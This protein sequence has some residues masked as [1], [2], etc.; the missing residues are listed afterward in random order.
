MTGGIFGPFVGREAGDQATDTVDPSNDRVNLLG[1]AGLLGRQ[2]GVDVNPLESIF[3]PSADS[4]ALRKRQEAYLAGL[5]AMKLKQREEE[6][7]LDFAMKKQLLEHEFG[8]TSKGAGKTVG[9]SSPNIQRRLE[10]EPNLDG[11]RQ[12]QENFQSP[13][14]PA[15]VLRDLQPFADQLTNPTGLG[16]PPSL[17]DDSNVEFGTFGV[18]PSA[19]MLQMPERQAQAAAVATD[20]AGIEQA[21]READ[22][23]LNPS[24]A[25]RERDIQALERGELD[26]GGLAIDRVPNPLDPEG[27]VPPD[28]RQ[29]MAAEVAGEIAARVEALKDLAKQEP[30]SGVLPGLQAARKFAGLDPVDTSEL[31]PNQ[32]LSK[33]D[34]ESLHAFNN[35]ELEGAAVKGRDDRLAASKQARLVKTI[36]GRREAQRALGQ[37]KG[38]FMLAAIGLKEQLAGSREAANIAARGLETMK[39]IAAR[40]KAS[41]TSDFYKRAAEGLD[42]AAKGEQI[43][44]KI[45]AAEINNMARISGQNIRTLFTA[46]VKSGAVDLVKLTEALSKG[47]GGASSKGLLDALRGSL[48]DVYDDPA[49]DTLQTEINNVL[50]NK[51]SEQTKATQLRPLMLGAM[52]KEDKRRVQQEIDRLDKNARTRRKDEMTANI[53][54]SLDPAATPNEIAQAIK[55]HDAGSLVTVGD[56]KSALGQGRAIDLMVG[57][58][59]E[60]STRADLQK[61]RFHLESAGA[62]LDD[63]QKVNSASNVGFFGKMRSLAY[64]VGAQGDAFVQSMI[65]RA[66]EIAVEVTAA[67]DD[68]RLDRFVDRDLTQFEMLAGIVTYELASAIGKQT[69]RGLS[70][71]DL[72]RWTKFLQF[73]AVLTGEGQ[74]DTVIQTARR[75]MAREMAI[76][77]RGLG[78]GGLKSNTSRAESIESATS[79][80]ELMKIFPDVF[81]EAP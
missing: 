50:G 13:A 80:E 58:N 6:L 74:I 30:L 79:M 48:K 24:S 41:A 26:R 8:L 15:Q 40:A 62:L 45:V 68:I 46:L 9:T 51:S 64:G 42:R 66:E 69:G 71:K 3:G 14:N 75:I 20:L 70:D 25:A 10:Q 12:P 38:G 4:L 17:M 11:I 57:Q 44:A 76:I 2:N 34:I 23:G 16:P 22:P 53:A 21:S 1:Q 65:G 59:L 63:L 7:K 73:D 72:D 61:Q 33:K 35:K 5:D 19:F 56:V 55:A 67:G 47:D 37:E 32:M 29:R 78:G 36:N 18:G 81:G 77:D 31:D 39:G 54:I 52:N 43:D 28:V 60:K 27:I 49:L